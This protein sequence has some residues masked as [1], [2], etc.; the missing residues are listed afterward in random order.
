MKPQIQNT[1]A[2][3]KRDALKL[4]KDIDLDV[5]SRVVF[6]LYGFLCHLGC[7]GLRLL[8]LLLIGHV[9]GQNLGVL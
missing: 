8:L 6:S 4:E 2:T 5:Y 9:G 1:S 3:G 7:T